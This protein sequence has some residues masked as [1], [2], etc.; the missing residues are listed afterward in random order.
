MIWEDGG[1]TFWLITNSQKIS[2]LNLIRLAEFI[3]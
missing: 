2:R 1:T 3:P